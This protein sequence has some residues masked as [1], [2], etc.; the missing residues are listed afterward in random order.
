MSREDTMLSILLETI[1]ILGVLISLAANFGKPCVDAMARGR[2]KRLHATILAFPPIHRKSPTAEFEAE[3]ANR[4][5][6]KD[7]QAMEDDNFV[8]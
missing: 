8:R 5:G 4:H 2:R 7:E 3:D 1:G 6:C